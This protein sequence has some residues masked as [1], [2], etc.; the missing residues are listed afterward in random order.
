MILIRVTFTAKQ[1]SDSSWEF[2]KTENKQVKTV[3]ND[4]YGS[5]WRETSY[6][7]VKVIN[8]KRQLTGKRRSCGTK[9]RLPFGENVILNLSIL[10][11]HLSS[12]WFRSSNFK[13]YQTS[14]KKTQEK[15]P[16]PFP[17]H[18]EE[19]LSISLRLL[20]MLPQKK[21]LVARV[22]SL[23]RQVIYQIKAKR[24][25]YLIKDFKRSHEKIETV[26]SLTCLP[27]MWPRFK[28]WRRRHI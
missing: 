6:F 11:L 3:Q 17:R 27:P 12:F 7:W 4:S 21:I 22:F 1:T 5:N 15:R 18:C 2:L 8:S 25:N 26:N 24:L 23:Q 10:S 14:L 19:G 28:S 16:P 20:L 9:S 13:D